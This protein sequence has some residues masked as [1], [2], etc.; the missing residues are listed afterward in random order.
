MRR[1]GRKPACLAAAFH[2]TLGHARCTP[3][4]ANDPEWPRVKRIVEIA[5]GVVTS[6]GGFLEAGS[7]TT[8]A[9][10]G[11]EFGMSLVWAVGL[12]T[13]CAIFLVE[14]SGRLAAVSHHTI[15]SAVRERFGFNFFL[16]PLLTV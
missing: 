16:V 6:I 7:M 11:S 13:L 1:S 3:L 9:Q 12:G 2:R 8:S 10:A 15:A 14:M 5:L 4:Q